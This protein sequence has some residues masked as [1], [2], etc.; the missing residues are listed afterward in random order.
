[1]GSSAWPSN[2]SAPHLQRS[3]SRG[4]GAISESATAQDLVEASKTLSFA[5]ANCD[6]CQVFPRYATTPRR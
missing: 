6:V 2:Q 5:K 3:V 1:M 4:Q